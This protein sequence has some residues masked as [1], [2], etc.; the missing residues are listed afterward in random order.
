[1]M[2]APL[3]RL[4]PLALMLGSTLLGRALPTPAHIDEL[5]DILFQPAEFEQA[6]LAPDGSH[7]AITREFKDHKVI[8]TFDL[9][10]HEMKA[11]RQ[12]ANQDVVNAH[13]TGP[14]ALIFYLLNQPQY[15]EGIF[16]VDEDLRDPKRFKSRTRAEFYYL[17]QTLPW[18][19]K[20]A[21]MGSNDDNFSSPLNRLN[22][23][24][25]AVTEVEANPGRVIAWHIDH[26]M[27]IA[28]LATAAGIATNPADPHKPATVTAGKRS[29]FSM[30]F[31][32]QPGQPWRAIAVPRRSQPV[33]FDPSGD[34]TLLSYP[35]GAGR[36]VLQKYDFRRQR[37]IDQPTG[38]PRHDL[39]VEAIINPATGV[40]VGLRYEA[41]KPQFIWLDP[42]YQRLHALLQQNFPGETVNL[43]GVLGQGKVIFSAA[44]DV[45][46]GILYEYDAPARKISALITARPAAAGRTWAK[47]TP[48]WFP[49]RDGY[50]VPAFLTLPPGR[51]SGQKVPMIA[52]SHG[53]PQARDQWGFNPE[54]QFLAALG[55]GVLQVN[56]RGS[57]GYGEKHELANHL[58]VH[59][60]SVDDVADGLQWTVAAGFADPGRL[61]AYGGSYGGYIS[62]ALATRYPDLLA[63]TV[64]FA[65]VYD[66]VAERKFDTFF[67]SDLF[68]WRADYYVDP[69]DHAERFAKVAPVQHADRIK[70]PVLLMHGGDD[71]TVDISQS[72]RMAAALQSARKPFEIVKDTQGIHG[73]PRAAERVTFYR[74]L[75]EFLLKHVPPDT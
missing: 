43:L 10:T 54:V 32:D 33:Y 66:W 18:D 34:S 24:T 45:A 62:L 26:Q 48:V 64:G 22:L 4:V 47:M 41:E 42:E 73:L 40:P 38:D 27:G 30:L 59:E 16:V 21:L 20:F 61:A 39:D 53:G 75:A 52:L 19:G 67:A 12:D 8:I 13:W 44:S 71:M 49:A 5:I 2:T 3:R 15:F 46:P 28:R 57:V 51:Q 9:N 55:Y 1:M 56:Y 72:K 36:R 74:R 14:N 31:R 6:S 7:L 60:Q 58:L 69:K 11:L 35:D 63:A 65:G 23:K 68:R 70:C 17:V 29:E 50:Q 37:L 25:L